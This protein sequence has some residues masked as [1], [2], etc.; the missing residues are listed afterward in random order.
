MISSLHSHSHTTRRRESFQELFGRLVLEQAVLQQE[1]Y[2]P[3]STH[4]DH[5]PVWAPDAVVVAPPGATA[6]QADDEP[7]S[8]FGAAIIAVEVARERAD[9]PFSVSSDQAPAWAP[10]AVLAPDWF[11]AR[12]S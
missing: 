6:G 11:L 7:V 8:E 10:D 3:S 12:Q 9:G 4:P 2:Q 5:A 1:S